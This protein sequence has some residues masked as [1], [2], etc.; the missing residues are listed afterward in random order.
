MVRAFEP[1]VTTGKGRI[2]TPSLCVHSLRIHG[3]DARFDD[4]LLPDGATVLRALTDDAFA[5]EVFG[6]PLLHETRWGARYRPKG[7]TPDAYTNANANHVDQTLASLIELGVPLTA[8][9]A[10]AHRRM[11][12]QDV[13]RDAISNFSLEE[14]ECEWTSVALA[15]ALPP[16]RTWSNRFGERFSFDTLAT[17]LAT[18]DFRQLSCGGTHVLYAMLVLDRVHAERPVLGA[19]AA[20]GLRAR[21]DGMLA[22]IRAS[23]RPDG[24]WDHRWFADR[25][26]LRDSKALRAPADLVGRIVMTG[27][28][29]ECLLLLPEPR[30]LP[31]EIMRRAGAWLWKHLPAQVRL[32][33]LAKNFCPLTHAAVVVGALRAH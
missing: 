33:S 27:H 18:R 24:S 9:L 4:T 8:P 31:H 3:L 23:Q 11:T 25:D 20:R 30:Q 12:I 10:L 16:T 5:R 28:I 29:G 17:H 14:P 1:R 22:R 26:T 32:Q 21:I 7:E 19:A 2:S 13:L 6:A 15:L